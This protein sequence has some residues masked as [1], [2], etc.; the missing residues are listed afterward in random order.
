VGFPFRIAGGWQERE[1][2][3]KLNQLVNLINSPP[4]EWAKHL[5]Y[6][7]D[8]SMHDDPTKFFDETLTSVQQLKPH[9]KG[10]TWETEIMSHVLDEIAVQMSTSKGKFLAILKS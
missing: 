7:F 2:T 4:D 10:D 6:V 1:A 5:A 3:Q 8:H 9:L